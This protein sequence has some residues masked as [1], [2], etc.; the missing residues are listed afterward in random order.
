MGNKAMNGGEGVAGEVDCT[1]K[2]YSVRAWNNRRQIMKQ[3][4]DDE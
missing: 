2:I 1:P 3:K 4:Q